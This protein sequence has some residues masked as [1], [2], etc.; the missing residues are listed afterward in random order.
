MARATAKSKKEMAKAA[1]DES[2]VLMERPDYLKD[3][4][5]SRGQET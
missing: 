1:D 5:S 2:Q 4:D 3:N